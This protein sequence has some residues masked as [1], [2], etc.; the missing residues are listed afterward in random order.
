MRSRL[1]LFTA[2]TVILAAFAGRQ[3]AHAGASACNVTA[4]GQHAR[5]QVLTAHLSA[6]CPASG[7]AGGA[8][9]FSQYPGTHG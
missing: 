4:V 7:T 8:L 6:G 1:L 9:S 5:D 3:S 2:V